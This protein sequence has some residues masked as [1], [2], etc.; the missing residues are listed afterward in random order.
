MERRANLRVQS[1]TVLLNTNVHSYDQNNPVRQNRWSPD[2]YEAHRAEI[3]LHRAAKKHFDTLKLKKLPTIATL[4]QEFA[5]LSAEK[6][7]LYNVNIG[8]A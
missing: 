7:K 8:S 1:E 5:E 2:F 6:N 3:T 4:K